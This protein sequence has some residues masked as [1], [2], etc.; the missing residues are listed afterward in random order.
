M[1]VS[2]PEG[3][4]NGNRQPGV[5]SRSAPTDGVLLDYHHAYAHAW[6]RAFG[7]MPALRDQQAYWP[8]DRWNVETLTGA[9]LTAFRSQFDD[10]FWSTVP[11][12]EGA[13]SACH[14]LVAAGFELVCVSALDASFADA[15]RRNLLAHGFPITAVIVT[16]QDASVKSPKAKALEKLKPVAFVDDFLH[17]H[18]G[19][20]TDIHKAL[21]RREE[22]GSPN[23]GA[24]LE[25][26]DSQH[27]NLREFVDWWLLHKGSR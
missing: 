19:L 6:S 10:Q 21:I 12:L 3:W 2:Q 7:A 1:R 4:V 15:R 13:V 24:E 26:V 5:N 23:V 14:D 9:K 27:L 16:D 25:L 8:R 17:Y 20:P 11:P 18:R 22:N